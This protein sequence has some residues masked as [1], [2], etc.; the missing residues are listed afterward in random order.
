MAAAGIA[1][2]TT[3][4][5]STVDPTT[6]E[7]ARDIGATGAGSAARFGDATDDMEFVEVADAIG[8]GG[9]TESRS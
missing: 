5:G 9:L 4:A 1:G 7:G 8:A 2:A 3:G 6:G